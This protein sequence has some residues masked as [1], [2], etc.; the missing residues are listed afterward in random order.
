MDMDGTSFA[1]GDAYLHAH[2]I[3]SVPSYTLNGS[4]LTGNPLGYN[5]TAMSAGDTREEAYHL[6]LSYILR[7][8]LVVL[9]G[10]KRDLGRDARGTL[11]TARPRPRV[12]GDQHIPSQGAFVFVAHHYE[13]QGLEV[14]G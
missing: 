1:L 13:R 11:M 5:R 6:P 3:R 2:L 8:I 10:R 9:L 7:F 12:I 14:G 4:L